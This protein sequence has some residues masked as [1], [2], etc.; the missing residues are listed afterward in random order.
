MWCVSKG[1]WMALRVEERKRRGL[2]YLFIIIINNKKG[3]GILGAG[4]HMIRNMSAE[5][6]G[7]WLINFSFLFPSWKIISSGFEIKN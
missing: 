2:F 4:V 5:S 7:M 6:G 3:E 1:I